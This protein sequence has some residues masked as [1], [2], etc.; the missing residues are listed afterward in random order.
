MA[1]L[2]AQAESSNGFEIDELPPAGNY[3]ATCLDIVDEFGSKS[4]QVSIGRNGDY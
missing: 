4:S 3:V 1:I 2:Q